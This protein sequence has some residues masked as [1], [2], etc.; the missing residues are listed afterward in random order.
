MNVAGD[1][2]S[3]GRQGDGSDQGLEEMGLG[4]VTPP[5]C[6]NTLGRRSDWFLRGLRGYRGGIIHGNVSV[7]GAT[8]GRIIHGNLCREPQT[9][10]EEEP[11]Q[12]GRDGFFPVV[13]IIR[14]PPMADAV[15][16]V[17]I[18]QQHFPSMLAM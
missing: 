14:G 15:A 3:P 17:S 7:S 2:R 13:R 11:T 1:K 6:E 9:T 5:L 18:F 16:A 8:I 10:I 12:H 4:A